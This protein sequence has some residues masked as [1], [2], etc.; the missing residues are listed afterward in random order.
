MRN[1]PC[2]QVCLVALAQLSTAGMVTFGGI[3][4]VLLLPFVLRLTSR[5]AARFD[6]PPSVSFHVGM[7]VYLIGIVSVGVSAAA[8]LDVHPIAWVLEYTFQG[9]KM[10]IATL[11]WWLFIL[12]IVLPATVFAATRFGV[13]LIIIR[14]LFHLFGAA[15]FLFPTAR[16][17]SFMRL[18]YGIA[19]GLMVVAELVRF[20]RV[21]PFAPFIESFVRPYTD[22]RDKGALV[23]THIYLLVG[24]ALPLWTCLLDDGG[25]GLLVPYAGIV[26]LG[27][28]DAASAIVGSLI[29]RHKWENGTSR[30]VEGSIAGFLAMVACC[31][32]A[33]RA[34]GD[35]YISPPKWAV[36][37]I[38]LLWT[39]ALEMSTSQIDNLLLPLYLSALLAIAGL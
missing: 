24:F 12:A 10:H 26:A 7:G 3:V 33:Q 37:L 8:N 29:G 28:G 21:Q 17:P 31:V 18:A 27:A 30:T 16:V 35:L 19:F 32:A 14:K 25:G 20:Y 22:E 38:I 11:V 36:L 15:M 13:R 23:L 1:R 5:I 39:S 2:R 34:A 9:S 4:G 6:L